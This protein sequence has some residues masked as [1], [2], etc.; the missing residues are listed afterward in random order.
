MSEVEFKDVDFHVEKEDYKRYNLK[1]GTLLK[2]KVVVRKILAHPQKTPQG[3]PLSIG[4]D[5]VNAISAIV[6]ASELRDPSNEPVNPQ[7]DIGDEI[8]FEEIGDTPLQ[9][10]MTDDG[11]TVTVKPIVTK[12]LKFKKWNIFGEPVYQAIIQAITNVEKNKG[13]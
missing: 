13:N 11:Y 9:R 6:R 12:V 5:S 10:Y 7:K 8:G 4:L 2:A 3:Y 1:D